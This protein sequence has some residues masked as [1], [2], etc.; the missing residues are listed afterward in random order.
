MFSTLSL[1]VN[2]IFDSIV[3]KL[4]SI[5]HEKQP[6]VS[7]LSNWKHI[8]VLSKSDASNAFSIKWW[9]K[10]EIILNSISYFDY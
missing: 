6:Q 3:N 8:L 1:K 2:E 7:S 10:N 9:N 4:S 5:G